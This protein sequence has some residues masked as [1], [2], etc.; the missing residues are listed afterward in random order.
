MQVWHF[1]GGIRSFGSVSL[2]A[3]GTCACKVSTRFI[4]GTACGS[5][6]VIDMISGLLSLS[7]KTAIHSDF[8][9]TLQPSAS[10]KYIISSSRDG[11]VKVWDLD[12]KLILS[13]VNTKR[14]QC[15]CF[16]SNDDILIGSG[17]QVE[18]I[19][20]PFDISSRCDHL[21]FETG[22][23]PLVSHMLI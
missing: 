16:L 1:S 9:R 21:P 11:T 22:S 14:M 23:R 6:H 10:D 4:V 17:R 18:I 3:A 15:A 7:L 13:M 5:V 2:P 20:Q 19:K 12:G 8:V